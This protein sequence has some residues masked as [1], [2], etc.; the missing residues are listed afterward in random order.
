MVDKKVQ[1]ILT[2]FCQ[3]KFKLLK[4]IHSAEQ[5]IFYWNKCQ[6]GNSAYFWGYP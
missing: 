6:S 3:R 1:G 2:Y 4:L 5:S